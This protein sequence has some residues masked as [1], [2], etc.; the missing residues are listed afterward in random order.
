MPLPSEGS[1]GEHNPGHHPGRR[2]SAHLDAAWG[3]WEI[4]YQL[5]PSFWGGGLASAMINALV[6]WFF[7]HM[8]EEILIA[9]TQDANERS[10]R[11]LERTGA[12]FQH[13]FVQYG[14]LQRQY[15]FRRTSRPQG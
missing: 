8:E 13:R 9:V 5:R 11:L 1:C 14:A 3:Q 2:R 15:E 6:E 7:S 4:S 10:T 12:T